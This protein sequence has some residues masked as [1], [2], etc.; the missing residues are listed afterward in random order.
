MGLFAVVVGGGGINSIWNPDSDILEPFRGFPPGGVKIITAAG[1]NPV[2]D[3]ISLGNIFA[4][5]GVE[6][7]WIPIHDVNCNENAF[8]EDIVAMVEAA[9]AIFYGGGQS[10]RLQSCLYGNYSQ[11]GIDVESGV[12][13]PVLQALINKVRYRLRPAFVLPFAIALSRSPCCGRGLQEVVG[14]SSAGAMN[15]PMSEIL[16]TGHSSESYA[17]AHRPPLP[18]RARCSPPSRW[19]TVGSAGRWQWC[20]PARSSS[21]TGATKCSRPKSSSTRTFQSAA[22]RAG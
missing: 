12:M 20:R 13:T 7:E 21:G 22:D 14:G 5:A 19:L 8:S 16:V 6:T 4:N 3:G 10:G 11:S 9:D 2:N 1:I 17:G 18:P 15:Q